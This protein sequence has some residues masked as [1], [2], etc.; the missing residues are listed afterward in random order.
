MTSQRP[1]SDRPR[2]LILNQYYGPAETTGRLLADLGEYLSSDFEV[3]VVAERPR[4]DLTPAPH[5]GLTLR[6]VPT[7]LANRRS[8]ALRALG[9]GAFLL[10]ALPRLFTARRPDAIV[11][12]TNPPVVGVLGLLAA[13]RHRAARLVIS[14]HDIHPDIG[15]VTGKLTSPPVVWALRKVQR[16]VLTRADLLVAISEPMRRRLLERGAKPTLVRVIPTWV[17]VDEITPHPRVNDWAREHGLGGRFTVMH[18][19]NAGLVQGLETFIDAAAQNPGVAHVVVGEGNAKPELIE[20]AARHELENVIF[21]AA[22]P[23]DRLNEMLAAADVHLVSLMPGLGGLMEPSK[24]CGILAAGR[25]VLAAIGPDGEAALVVE[26]TGCGLVAAPG[27]VDALA[28]AIA[29]LEGM[30]PERREEMGRAGRE[31][32]ERVYARDRVLPQYSALLAPSR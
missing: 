29:E 17:D 22:Q 2:L 16:L 28:A 30:S 5:T 25:P 23:R 20:R 3:E 6:W 21:I 15:L 1:H 24:L 27:S 26:E 13:R 11:C 9:Y 10:G 7:L 4:A 19:G 14:V 8:L 31:Y 32:A 12:V 18:A